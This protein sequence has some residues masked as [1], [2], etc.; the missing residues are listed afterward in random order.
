M[1]HNFNFE[2]TK[3]SYVVTVSVH[4]GKDAAGN[5]DITIDATIDVTINLTN[6]NEAPAIVTGTSG[7]ASR[8]NRLVTELIGSYRASDPDALTTL[9]WTVEG[10]DA[11]LFDITPASDTT[12]GK[13]RFRVSPNYEM[14]ENAARDNMYKVTVRVSDGF[15]S[16]T[17]VST[18]SVTN[19]N[20][21]PTITSPPNT[22]TFAENAT[23]DRRRLRRN[24]HRHRQDVDVVGGVCR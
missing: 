5:D 9:T 14:P 7:G 19:V 21:A 3:N 12:E 2:A 10:A 15:L 20:E 8:E 24:G 16:D 1:T 4:D 6:V 22:A 11:N 13:L 23:G 17:W 18:I